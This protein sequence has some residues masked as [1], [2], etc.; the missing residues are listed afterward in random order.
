MESVFF[1]KSRVPVKFSAHGEGR[2]GCGGRELSTVL[3]LA[4]AGLMLEDA[5][6]AMGTVEPLHDS[7]L[8]H[9]TRRGARDVGRWSDR[10]WL[11]LGT[12][13]RLPGFKELRC[14]MP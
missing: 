2:G 10:D 4:D 11:P 14:R 12:L 6:T 9:W 8:L 7:A 5:R 3:S 1:L 13:V